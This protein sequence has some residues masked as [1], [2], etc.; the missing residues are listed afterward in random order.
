M[1]VEIEALHGLVVGMQDPPPAEELVAGSGGLPTAVLADRRTFSAAELPG[2]I[3]VMPK[4]AGFRAGLR[5]AL[6][7]L[8]L[9]PWEV[10]YVTDVPWDVWD[11]GWA[12]V[13]SILVAPDLVYRAPIPDFQ[14]TSFAEMADIVD[15]T[16]RG[17]FSELVAAGQQFK[18]GWIISPPSPD[19]LRAAGVDLSVGGRYFPKTGDHRGVCHALSIRIG[20]SKGGLTEAETRIPGAALAGVL[21]IAAGGE[22]A[23]IVW[24]PPRPGD[25]DRLG[26]VVRDAVSRRTGLVAQPRLVE[27]I[28]SYPK[29]HLGVGR[30]DPRE[31]EGAFV[32]RGDCRGLHVIVCDDVVTSAQTAA[33]VAREIQAAGAARVAVA[34]L[35]RTDNL[36]SGPGESLPCPRDGCGGSRVARINGSDG[37]LFWGCTNYRPDGCRSSARWHTGLRHL[38]RQNDRESIEPDVEF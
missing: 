36:E 1:F 13:G 2:N 34:A 23:A 5:A 17:Y 31:L 4:T 35:A 32:C 25:K 21:N 26:P 33:S 18:S 16:D 9:Q 22:R 7:H 37:E 10:A 12:H 24:V 19:A 30:R 27:C 29:R 20:Q 38:R 28:R 11:V 8:R 3:R 6:D 14:V 15:G